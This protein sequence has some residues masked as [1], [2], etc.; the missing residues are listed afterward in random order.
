M[1]GDRG[2]CFW[3]MFT[4][5]VALKLEALVQNCR[6]FEVEAINEYV[7]VQLFTTL[8]KS[9]FITSLPF[10]QRLLTKGKGSFIAF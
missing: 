6:H 5:G 7:C 10:E 3:R 1:S 9:L 2:K 4:M 8:Y